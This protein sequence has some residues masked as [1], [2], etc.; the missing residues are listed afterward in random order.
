LAIAL[1]VL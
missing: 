1:T